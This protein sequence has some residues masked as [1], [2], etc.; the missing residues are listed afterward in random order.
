MMARRAIYC[1]TLD[2]LHSGT[3][4]KN[5]IACAVTGGSDSNLRIY[6][7]SLTILFPCFAPSPAVF[8]SVP[9]NDWATP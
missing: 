5:R 2:G 4:R 1:A 6:S 9:N 3:L 8:L 7:A